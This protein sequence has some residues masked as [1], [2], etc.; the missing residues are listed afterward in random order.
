MFELLKSLTGIVIIVSSVVAMTY[1]LFIQGVYEEVNMLKSSFNK[2]FL[3]GATSLLISIIVLGLVIVI[4]SLEH[5]ITKKYFNVYLIFFDIINITIFSCLK[6]GKFK[7]SKLLA[8]LYLGINIIIYALF[9]NIYMHKYPNTFSITWTEKHYF[10]A[11]FIV[12]QLLI[13]YIFMILNLGFVF[14]EIK[15]NSPNK[16]KLI[17]SLF[18][19]GEVTCYILY[20]NETEITIK[21]EDSCVMTIK[22]DKVDKYIHMSILPVKKTGS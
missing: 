12:M 20:E 14:F 19:K 18:E 1:F 21:C 6:S 17:S 9:I 22:K 15:F 11:I 4:A 13:P 8:I 3:K 16:I 2:S 5:E 7:M 10:I